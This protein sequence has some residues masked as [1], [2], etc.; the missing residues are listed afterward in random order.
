MAENGMG[1]TGNPMPG[2]RRSLLL[3]SLERY[4]VA[5]V[6]FLSLA[7]TA[8]LLGPA[9]FGIAM[10]GF[11]I[12]GIAEALRECGAASYI[13]QH[14]NLTD[15]NVRTAFTVMMGISIVLVAAVLIAARPL[16][17]WFEVPELENYLHLVIPGL[18]LGPIVSTSTAM[19]RRNMQ[20]GKVALV[21]IAASTTQMALLV[22][23]AYH[24][25][26][27]ASFAY[28]VLGYLIAGIAMI[29]VLG[30]NIGLFKPSLVEWRR[31]LS[32]AAFDTATILLN[33]VWE[34]L[35]TLVFARVL[36]VSAVGTYSRATSVCQWPEKAL[37]AGVASVLLPAFASGVRAGRSLKDAYLRA[38][39]YITAL[40]WP[41]LIMLIILA[42]P[43][44]RIMLG[45]KW[46]NT[47]ELVQII[48][49][50]ML[51]WFPSYLS[52]PSLVAAGAIRDALF[53]SL[54]SLPVSGLILILVAPYGLRTVAMSMFAIFPVQVLIAL[55]FVKNRLGFTVVEFLQAMRPSLTVAA[56]TLAGPALSILVLGL[57]PAQPID[58][59]VIAV[60]GAGSWFLGIKYSNHP[61][62]NEIALIADIAQT[63][64]EAFAERHSN[65]RGRASDA[66]QTVAATLARVRR[67]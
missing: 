57:D 22:T 49:G 51:F 44:V 8:R 26:G 53:A 52:Y 62:G 56:A 43:I 67:Q 20:F 13:I 65:R 50:A 1:S 35:P 9:D 66:L 6:S 27:Y 60:V 31:A 58:A 2:V 28:G 7:I 32:F 24:G 39:T 21:S 30:I 12:F 25:F 10:L 63:R 36:G 34:M 41:A 18:L 64:L 33:R 16:A 19:F 14:P 42:E 45:S 55:Y 61:I 29:A 40:Q 47:V 59:V 37:F 15:S 48:A 46:A 54:I 4:I 23:L 5:I 11:S 17:V 3:A 38:I